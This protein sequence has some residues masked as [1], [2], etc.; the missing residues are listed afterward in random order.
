MADIEAD[1]DMAPEAGPSTLT[2]AVRPSTS[3]FSFDLAAASARFCADI[4]CTDATASRRA[5]IPEVV[6]NAAFA[7]HVEDVSTADLTMTLSQLISQPGFTEP[8]TT[9]FGP[10]LLPILAHW[11]ETD[12][13]LSVKEWES[14]LTV[15]AFVAPLRPALWR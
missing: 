15:M 4:G 12:T 2:N 9:H 8:I 5:A 13:S 7:D 6:V 10:V 11:L 3:P 14:R 1:I